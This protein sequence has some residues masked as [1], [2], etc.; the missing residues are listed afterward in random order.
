MVPATVIVIS[1]LNRGAKPAHTHHK[2]P[3]HGASH[4]KQ[5]WPLLPENIVKAIVD[6]AHKNNRKVTAHIAEVRGAQIAV[7]S[8]VDEWAHMPCER[9]P[10]I[11]VKKSGGAKRKNSRYAGYFIEMFGYCAQCQHLDGPGRRTP[12]WCR[13][14][15]PRYSVGYRC[16]GTYVHDANG[17]NGIDRCIACRDIKSRSATENVPLLGT[18]QRDAPADIIAVRGDPAH[19]LKTL[20]YPD[21]VISGGKIIVNNF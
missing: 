12:V 2:P 10:R 8:G 6:E 19:N 1:M 14:C 16:A 5:A 20:E 18:L 3:A 21:S 4:S 9:Y 17:K 11:A 7:N 13:N 15:A